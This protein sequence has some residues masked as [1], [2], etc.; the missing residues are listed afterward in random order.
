[1]NKSA[2]ENPY[3]SPAETS[4]TPRRFDED[5]TF[6]WG[7]WIMPIISAIFTITMANLV[8]F[9]IFGWFHGVLM[10]G[11]LV[12]QLLGLALTIALL[13]KREKTL[14]DWR[15]LKRGIVVNVITLVI[16]GDAFFW[17]LSIST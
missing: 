3:C 13:R 17:L 2:D 9:K 14:D 7:C 16:N 1:M 5:S 15:H 11:A 8:L 12:G 4:V 6:A 10:L